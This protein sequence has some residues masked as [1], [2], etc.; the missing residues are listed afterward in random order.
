M[1]MREGPFGRTSSRWPTSRFSATFRPMKRRL[2]LD[3]LASKTLNG[4]EI[5]NTM[6][7]AQALANSSGK[8]L[9]YDLLLNILEIVEQFDVEDK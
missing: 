3:T 7:T 4:R 1:N 5:K 8:R 9:G 6:R 2:Q